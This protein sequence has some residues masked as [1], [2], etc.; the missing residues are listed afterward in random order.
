[1]WLPIFSSS[2]PRNPPVL[3]SYKPDLEFQRYRVRLDKLKRSIFKFLFPPVTTIGGLFCMKPQ[4]HT[5]KKVEN[6]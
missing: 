5:P 3:L 2:P 1:M 6:L 4:H